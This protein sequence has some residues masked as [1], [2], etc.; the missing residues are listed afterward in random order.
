MN[1]PIY[2]NS[3]DKN[4]YSDYMNNYV[5]SNSKQKYLKN[6]NS[7]FSSNITQKNAKSIINNNKLS[8]NNIKNRKGDNLVYRSVLADL[9]NT[10]F[11]KNNNNTSKNKDEFLYQ[12]Y[13][14]NK[15]SNY[16]NN[17]ILKNNINE[18]K[19]YLSNDTNKKILSRSINK[20]DINNSYNISIKN[21]NNK[22]SNKGSNNNLLS[23]KVDFFSSKN[24]FYKNYYDN[25]FSLAQNFK[26]QNGNEKIDI[27]NKNINIYNE[28]FMD[29]NEFIKNIKEI[30][31][32]DSINI[33]SSH[34]ILDKNNKENSKLFNNDENRII[35]GANKDKINIKN[36]LNIY[37][38]TP[39][40][41]QRNSANISK[42]NTEKK[43]GKNVNYNRISLKNKSNN[44]LKTNTEKK[45]NLNIKF[46]KKISE[47]IIPNLTDNKRN[48]YLNNLDSNNTFSN[49]N[50][51]KENLNNFYNYENDEI[52][53][54][55]ISKNFNT[56]NDLLNINSQVNNNTM[57]KKFSQKLNISPYNKKRFS[58]LN[59]DNDDNIEEMNLKKSLD[60]EIFQNKNLYRKNYDDVYNELIDIKKMNNKLKNEVIWL[61][62]YIQKRNQIIQK[63]YS[64]INKKQILI[65]K[66]IKDNEVKLNQNRNLVNQVK[67]LSNELF[68][69]KNEGEEHINRNLSYKMY[70]ENKYIKENE[71]LKEAIKK[72]EFENN[73]LKILL[74]KSKEKQYSNDIPGKKR[75]KS[76]VNYSENQKI[77]NY[78]DN[79]SVSVPR[80]KNKINIDKSI[81]KIYKYTKDNLNKFFIIKLIYL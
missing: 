17:I 4:L 22:L 38:N 12:T 56:F 1:F 58:T 33:E 23:K 73:K 24:S 75:K 70:K 69:I 41:M 39:I 45:Q 61:K 40:N 25:N 68:L 63:L 60:L 48:N 43:E 6:E 71:E 31:D 74:L 67:K 80:M 79:K 11:N 10:S 46:S 32:L 64:D 54:Y 81:S 47:K 19:N 3:R 57:D 52:K 37:N 62:K 2:S 30:Q 53:N 50:I 18:L 76:F 15:K 5:E 55:D 51:K 49:S 26:N 28:I 9:E 35:N 27:E 65:N 59:N 77:F 7:R 21:Q 42:L 34:V 72:F 44:N 13:N 20:H 78:K 36:S 66:L 8:Y 29:K 14:N 16:I